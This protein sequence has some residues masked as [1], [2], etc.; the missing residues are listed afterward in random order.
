MTGIWRTLRD[1]ILWSYE[2][3]TIQYDVMVTLILLFIF[4]SPYWIN[5]QDKPRLHDPHRTEVVV[6]ADGHGGLIFQIATNGFPGE[7]D[8]EVKSELSR[9]IEPVSG[10]VVITKYE[11]SHSGRAVEYRVWAHRQ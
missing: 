10:K 5:F 2:R 7:N 8:D 4:L 3:G 6:V 11:R 1:Y 9:I